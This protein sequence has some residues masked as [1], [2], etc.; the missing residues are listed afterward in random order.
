[1]SPCCH[2]N[3]FK[4]GLSIEK[5]RATAD[6]QGNNDLVA[7]GTF[8]GGSESLQSADSCPCRAQHSAEHLSD[9]FNY[10]RGVFLLER[11]R[12][13]FSH[14]SFHEQ[15]RVFSFLTSIERLQ[16]VQLP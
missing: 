9:R 13:P 15:G 12:H 4:R 7:N 3:L 6:Y 1:M 14:P 2:S 16:L 5:W 11:E 8:S 10:L